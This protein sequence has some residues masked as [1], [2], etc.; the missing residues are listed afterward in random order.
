MGRT[1][2]IQPSATRIQRRPAWFQAGVSFL[3]LALAGPW[4]VAADATATVMKVV[5]QAQVV[6]KEKKRAELAE[7]MSLVEGA[8]V[9]TGTNAIVYLDFGKHDHALAVTPGSE[10]VIEKLEIRTS[11]DLSG[12]NTQIKV[13]KGSS[14]AYAGKLEPV[15]LYALVSAKGVAG[16]REGTG[17]RV[18]A[19]GVLDCA[20]GSLV[21]L[22]PCALS[23]KKG[24]SIDASRSLAAFQKVNAQDLKAIDQ[25][26]RE[27]KALQRAARKKDR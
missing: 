6:D 9:I 1:G 24:E 5:G 15:S 19:E 22:A 12:F 26:I 14:V 8:T 13:R 3:C 4:A 20:E 21:V 11:G 16:L 10:V 17:G 25:L 18:S 27:L 23:I 2:S 7:G